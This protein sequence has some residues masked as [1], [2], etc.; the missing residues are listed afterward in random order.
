MSPL[1][2][3]DTFVLIACLIYPG[4]LFPSHLPISDNMKG[5]K[6]ISALMH[7]ATNC[8]YSNEALCLLTLRTL[9]EY[10]ETPYLGE[11]ECEC[12]EDRVKKVFLKQYS[13]YLVLPPSSCMVHSRAI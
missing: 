12:E 3:V 10:I 11:S 5:R 6:H 8:A 13:R 4:E 1:I 9:R 7:I 2:D